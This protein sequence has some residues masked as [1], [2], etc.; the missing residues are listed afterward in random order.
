MT[1]SIGHI[2]KII[3]NL[4][5]S[6][7]YIGS[8]FNQLRHRWQGH[9][10]S[11]KNIRGEMDIHKYFDKYDIK[12]FKII[13]IKSYNCFRENLFDL[14]HLHAYETLWINKTKNCINKRLPF[15]P[16]KPKERNKIYRQ[17]NKNKIANAKKIYRD[18]NL[19]KFKNYHKEY[20]QNNKEKIL[21]KMKE[22]VKCECG[23]IVNKDNLKRHQ[24]SKKHINLLNLIKQ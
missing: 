23:C 6:F 16:I 12:N 14:K 2:Y 1:H 22:K 7:C 15:T 13:L 10:A 21:Q 5:S 17:N 4:D 19:E 3:C 8:T 11:Y 18:N 24:R 9:K 20:Y